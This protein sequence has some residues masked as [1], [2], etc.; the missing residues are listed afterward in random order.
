[1]ADDGSKS[2]SSVPVLPISLIQG[3]PGT[4]KTHTVKGILNTWHLIQFQRHM[5]GWLQQAQ[6][7]LRQQ[8]EVLQRSRNAHT[9]MAMLDIS[10]LRELQSPPSAPKPRILVCAPSNAGACVGVCWGP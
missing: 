8:A 2:R 1:M 4:G 9:S 3:P 10:Y 7:A 5:D 6:A